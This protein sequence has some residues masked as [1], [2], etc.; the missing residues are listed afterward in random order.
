ML[1]RRYRTMADEEESI[2][3]IDMEAIAKKRITQD[4]TSDLSAEDMAKVAMLKDDDGTDI[5]TLLAMIQ[6]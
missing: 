5:V 6:D 4:I 2:D 1:L 3:N